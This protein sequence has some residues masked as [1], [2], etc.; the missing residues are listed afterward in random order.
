MAFSP[1]VF[2]VNFNSINEKPKEL[3]LLTQSQWQ[4]QRDLIDKLLF[5]EYVS[6][7]N[8][9]LRIALN[10]LIDVYLDV[11]F[12]NCHNQTLCR[13]FLNT[14]D[15]ISK[16]RYLIGEDAVNFAK[17]SN[18]LEE[19][20]TNLYQ[21]LNY[22]HINDDAFA[23]YKANYT[24]I[25]ALIYFS[26]SIHESSN[27]SD[28]HY[29]SQSIS[30]AAETMATIKK[31][32]KNNFSNSYVTW[33][34]ALACQIARGLCLECSTNFFYIEKLLSF[35]KKEE[36]LQYAN[37]ILENEDLKSEFYFLINDFVFKLNRKVIKELYCKHFNYGF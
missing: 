36:L 37:V 19:A 17:F 28:V 33:K 5:L 34:Q 8:F 32:D 15:N 22:I 26:Y 14:A 18:Q 23:L 3:E 2:A 4:Q 10:V 12:S 1:T 27:A 24:F 35:S 7:K 16:S 11:D 30:E 29:I 6:N 13:N 21:Q 9:L 31:I 25:R 20:S